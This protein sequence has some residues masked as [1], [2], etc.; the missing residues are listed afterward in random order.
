M[1]QSNKILKQHIGKAGTQAAEQKEEKVLPWIFLTSIDQLEQQI[2][3]LN[4]KKK[5]N[6]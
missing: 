6:K 4:F 2:F 5:E 3:S 1:G